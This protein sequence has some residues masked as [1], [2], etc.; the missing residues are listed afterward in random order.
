MECLRP[1]TIFSRGREYRV[2][3]G[4]CDACLCNKGNS[5]E[6]LLK[7][8]SSHSKYCY[9]VTLTYDNYSLPRVVASRFYD[10][11]GSSRVL[12]SYCGGASSVSPL[13]R[14]R[15]CDW[16]LCDY[17]VCDIL[18]ESSFVSEDFFKAFEPRFNFNYSEHPNFLGTFPVL[19]KRH[20]QNFLKRVR[21]TISYYISENETVRYYACGE[22]GTKHFRPHYHLLLFFE[23]GAVAQSIE[24]IVRSCWKFGRVDVQL[25]KGQC[26]GYVSK[27]VTCAQ[28]VPRLYKSSAAIRPFSLHSRYF[29]EKVLEK[30]VANPFEKTSRLLDRFPYANGNRMAHVDAPASYIR[31]FFPKCRGYALLNSRQRLTAYTIIRVARQEIDTPV[32]VQKLS[33]LFFENRDCFPVTDS[34]LRSLYPDMNFAY[35]VGV[36][37]SIFNISRQFLFLMERY[38]MSERALLFCIERYYIK[39]ELRKLRKFYESQQDFIQKFGYENRIHLISMYDNYQPY[40]NF[41]QYIDGKSAALCDSLHLSYAFIFADFIRLEDSPSYKESSV[42]AHTEI[43]KHQKHRDLNDLNHIFEMSI[44][45]KEDADKLRLEANKYLITL[46]VNKLNSKENVKCNGNAE[47]PQS[48]S[49]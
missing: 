28:Y 36:V 20:V 42:S 29:G 4:K 22:Y 41:S 21:K 23:S 15:D 43:T 39:Y 16:Q 7:I 30:E 14:A 8:E 5:M 45:E 1:R 49:S 12:L 44:S 47:C 6:S 13:S 27:Y 38:S 17:S 10:T 3:C 32:T 40:N 24:Q 25:S 26:A 48:C 33:E 11:E 2:A 34:I 37:L 31:R 18:P 19:C 46:F 9:F 35:D